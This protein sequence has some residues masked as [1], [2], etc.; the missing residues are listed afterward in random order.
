MELTSGPRNSEV[1]GLKPGVGRRRGG[2]DYREALGQLLAYYT[3]YSRN[4]ER[5]IGRAI[6]P[7]GL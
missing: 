4:L 3:V 2:F 1:P 7:G 6:T 5:R